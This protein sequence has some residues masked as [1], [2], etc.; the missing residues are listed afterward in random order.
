[1]TLIE[2]CFRDKEG[3]WSLA[4]GTINIPDKL[5]AIL[6]FEEV[7]LQ[8]LKESMDIALLY[9]VAM[10]VQLFLASLEHALVP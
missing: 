8:T 3:P 9:I 4:Q 5:D 2:N 1:M 10:L 6:A 7:I